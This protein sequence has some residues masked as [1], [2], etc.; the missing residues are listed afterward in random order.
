MGKLKRYAGVLAAIGLLL[1]AFTAVPRMEHLRRA[2]PITPLDS[3]VLTRITVERTTPM[4]VW[5]RSTSMLSDWKTCLR[6]NENERR[7]NSPQPDCGGGFTWHQMLTARGEV[8]DAVSDLLPYEPALDSLLIE[9]TSTKPNTPRRHEL[10]AQI[11][12]AVS[13]YLEAQRPGLAKS[14]LLVHTIF[15]LLVALIVGGLLCAGTT[16]KSTA[17]ALRDKA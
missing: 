16:G 10:D 6:L 3:T 12:T 1:A 14:I 8:G 4:Q 7:Y 9:Y 15:A 17:K 13:K 11:G 5:V 2:T